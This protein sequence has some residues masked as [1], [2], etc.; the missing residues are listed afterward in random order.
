MKALKSQTAKGS[1]QSGFDLLISKSL[2]GDD[3]SMVISDDCPVGCIPTSGL[4][5]KYSGG[6]IHDAREVLSDFPLI[7]K[8]LGRKEHRKALLGDEAPIQEGAGHSFCY[9]IILHT[10]K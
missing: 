5:V 8:A 1:A 7:G 9:L 3:L 4:K 2:K 10:P 6:A